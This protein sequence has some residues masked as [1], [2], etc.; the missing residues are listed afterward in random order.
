MTQQRCKTNSDPKVGDEMPD[1]TIYAG[2]SPDTLKPMFAA[3]ADAPKTLIFSESKKYAAE[4]IAHGHD[5]WH[6]PT[7]RELAMLFN[8]RAAI[9]GFD[10]GGHGVNPDG[11][12]WSSTQ[13]SWQTA[14]KQS[15]MDGEQDSFHLLHPLYV[16]CIRHGSSPDLASP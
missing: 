12:Y 11:S 14:C 9:G 10:Q 8:N 4:L 2:L 16:R 5:D 6:V 3:A 1:G 15:F 13:D 7:K